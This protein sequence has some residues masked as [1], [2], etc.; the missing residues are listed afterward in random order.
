MIQFAWL[1]PALPLLSFISL[2]AMRKTSHKIANSIA[3]LLSGLTFVLSIV[4]FIETMEQSGYSQV[5]SWLTIG[6]IDISFGVLLNPLNSVMLILVA[7]ISFL[8]H[9]YSVGYMKGD[10][11]INV[12]FAYLALF[13]SAMLGLVISPNLL[14][15]YM[16][17]ELVGLGSFLLIGFYFYKNSAKQA[18]KKAFIVTRIGDMGLL[19][20]LIL[21]FWQTGSLQFSEIFASIS[22]GC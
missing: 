16:F 12:Y 14:Q 1:I 3:L 18:A 15:F 6:S 22:S 20:G 2:L 10:K 19:I 5:W 21:L 9:L 11:R 7:F 8:I 4:V 13:T 17:W